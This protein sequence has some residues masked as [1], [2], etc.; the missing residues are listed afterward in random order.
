MQ[1]IRRFIKK[2]V[3]IELNIQ[4]KSNQTAQLLHKPYINEFILTGQNLPLK[5]CQ[6]LDLL[7][8]FEEGFMSFHTLNIGSVGQRAA[9]LLS[10]KL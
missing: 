6:T 3:H 8:H 7:I 1:K 4:L 9:K 2:V 5:C 10:I